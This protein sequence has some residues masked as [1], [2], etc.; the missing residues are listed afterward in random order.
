MTK[1][2]KKGSNIWKHYAV[3]TSVETVDFWVKDGQLF[4]NGVLSKVVPV[5]RKHHRRLLKENEELMARVKE[6]EQSSFCEKVE[7]EDGK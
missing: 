4:V 1:P 5:Y 6:L 3:V 2:H 7:V